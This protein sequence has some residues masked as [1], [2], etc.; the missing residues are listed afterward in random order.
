VQAWTDNSVYNGLTKPA[1]DEDKR[2]PAAKA[3]LDDR[4]VYMVRPLVITEDEYYAGYTMGDNNGVVFVLP[5]KDRADLA[6][7]KPLL[8]V[9]KL[10]MACT[11]N[12]I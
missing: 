11:P 5:N 7:K 8:E 4:G 3:A 9:A 10:L 12:G 2:S 6:S 1:H